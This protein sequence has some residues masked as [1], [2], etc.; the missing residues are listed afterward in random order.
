MPVS[1]GSLVELSLGSKVARILDARE[2]LSNL[3]SKYGGKG[4]GKK[5]HASGFVRE[6]ASKFCGEVRGDLLSILRN[7][8]SKS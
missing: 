3:L 6:D 7:K 4:G 8:L 1:S 5:D 2:V